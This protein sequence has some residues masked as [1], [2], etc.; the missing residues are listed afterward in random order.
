MTDFFDPRFPDSASLRAQ[1]QKSM[2]KFA[3]EYLEGGCI[4]EIGLH[5]NTNE[6][7]QVRLRSELLSPSVDVDTSVDLFGHKSYLEIKEHPD[8][9]SLKKQ[10]LKYKKKKDN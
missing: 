6:L 1:A 5:R 8:F 2:P 7:Q 9:Y 3:F 10:W 4:D